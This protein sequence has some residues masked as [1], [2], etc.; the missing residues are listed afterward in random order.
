MKDFLDYIIVGPRCLAA[1]FVKLLESRHVV[2]NRG[3][4]HRVGHSV[5]VFFTGRH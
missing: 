3:M 4:Y 1:T 2:P 5:S